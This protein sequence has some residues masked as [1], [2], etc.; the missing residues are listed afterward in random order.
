MLGGNDVV[1][2]RPR[3]EVPIGSPRLHS[4]GWYP[5]NIT[6]EYRGTYNSTS[7]RRQPKYAESL[8]MFGV[9]VASKLRLSSDSRWVVYHDPVLLIDHGYLDHFVQLAYQFAPGIRVA[10]SGGVEPSVLDN[11]P[12]EYSYIGRDLFLFNLGANATE[13]ASNYYG[14]GDKIQAAESALSRARSVQ[15]RADVRF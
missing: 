6:F 5:Q 14:L 11:V 3:L 10:I 12:N 7:L 15:V 13:A 4:I 1:T 2:I 9:D 8:F